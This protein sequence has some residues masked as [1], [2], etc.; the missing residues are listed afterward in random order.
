MTRRPLPLWVTWWGVSRATTRA[1]R[2]MIIVS[3]GKRANH[4]KKTSRLSQVF[5][6]FSSSPVFSVPGFLGSATAVRPTD[7][8]STTFTYGKLPLKLCNS[9]VTFRPSPGFPPPGFRR[10]R[11]QPNRR[12]QHQEIC[13]LHFDQG[14]HRWQDRCQ[15][16]AD[17]GDL[18]TMQ[19]TGFLAAITLTGLVGYTHA[20][21]LRD[22]L[23][24]S[25]YHLPFDQRLRFE[26]GAPIIVLGH[27]LEVKEIGPP[28]GS[29]ADPRIKTQLT[30]IKIDIEEVIK[31]ALISNPIEFYYFTFS[32]S[33]SEEHT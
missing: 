16:E 29:S 8:G 13:R 25:D 11:E 1:R 22:Q 14:R 24:M 2:A 7:D 31:G 20:A 5:P 4:L 6:R 18:H 27:V 3:C 33:A 32:P 30:Q 21:D 12:T 26:M 23:R 19:I 10:N 9:R 17:S 15:R 28:K